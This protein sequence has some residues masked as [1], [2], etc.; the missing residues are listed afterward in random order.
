[1]KVNITF[2]TNKGNVSFYTIDAVGP[3]YEPKKYEGYNSTIY[4]NGIE[5]HC[6]LTL[7][8]L[9][10]KLNNIRVQNESNK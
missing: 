4:S 10:G 8:E 3:N 5:F 1:M 7:A 9:W 6:K 2:E